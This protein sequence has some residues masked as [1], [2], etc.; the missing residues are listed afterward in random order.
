MRQSLISIVSES[1]VAIN[2]GSLYLKEK[3]GGR[4]KVESRLWARLD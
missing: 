4:E 2:S 3:G 1:L